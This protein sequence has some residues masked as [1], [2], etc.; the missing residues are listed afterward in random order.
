MAQEDLFESYY[1][2]D[3]QDNFVSE[4]DGCAV[5]AWGECDPDDDNETECVDND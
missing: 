5:E 1:V 3:A 4:N 2:E